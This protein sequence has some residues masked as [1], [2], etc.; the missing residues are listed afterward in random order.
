MLQPFAN[1]LIRA[2]QVG[3]GDTLAIGRIGHHDAL[4]LRLGEVLEVALRHGDV[5]GQSGSLDVQKCRID[6]LDVDIVAI[7]VVVEL[8]LL[9]VV[10]IDFVE[11]FGVEVGPFL[12]SILLAE[13]ARCHVVSDECRLDKQ[14]AGAAH[15]VDEVTL[16]LPAG[17]KDDAG[18]QHLVDGR[19]DGLLPVAAP[20]QGLAAGVKAQRTLVVGNMDVQPDV[21]V[22]DTDVRPLSRLLA[23]LVNNGILHLVGH[24]LRMPELVREDDRVDGKGLVDRQI[25]GPVNILHTLVDVV[26]RQ[27][28]EVL[29]G[30]E[31]A[32]GGVQLEVGTV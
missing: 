2:Q 25:A 10:I 7:N 21:G 27:R 20:V 23:E 12:E 8:A 4:L 13:Q 5:A 26:G 3:C 11:Q 31:D 1:H 14:R 18:C 29:D 22:G 16:A 9:G 30:F 15:G 32:D 24:E 17:H 6:R 19:F 28:L